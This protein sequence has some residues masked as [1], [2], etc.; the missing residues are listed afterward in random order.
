ML[1]LVSAVAINLGRDG[2]EPFLTDILKPIHRE[3]EIPS[4]FKGIFGFAQFFFSWFCS[5]FGRWLHR[6]SIE[7]PCR[8]SQVRSPDEPALVSK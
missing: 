4:S 7:T 1:R 8:R 2:V 6:Q 5:T 3:L